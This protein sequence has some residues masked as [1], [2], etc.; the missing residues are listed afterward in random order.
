[1]TRSRRPRFLWLAAAA[2]AHRCGAP[3]GSF[4][5]VGA[6][7]FFAGYDVNIFGLATPQI[8]HSLHIAENHIG[9]T[10][11]YFRAAALVALLI[12]ASADL[13]GRRRLLLVT[14]F[15][16]AIFTLLTAFAPDYRQFVGRAVPDPRVRLCRGDAVLRGDGGGNR[17][18]GARLGQRRADRAGISWARAWPSAVFGGGGHP[19]AWLAGAVC[20]RR[21]AAVPGGVPAAAPAGD[22]ALR[23]PGRSRLKTGAAPALLRDMARQYP[24]RIVTIIIA[25]AAFGFA[26]SPATFL[27]QKYLQEAYHYTP[28]QVS[29]LLIPGGLV[30]LG[31]SIAAGRLSDRIGRKPMAIAMVALSGVSFSLF[32]GAAPA[33]A[34]PPLWILAFFGFFCRRYADRGLR[35]GDRAHPLPRHGGRPALLI[36]IRPGAGA[37]ALEGHLYDHFHGHGPAF[38][39]CWPPFRLP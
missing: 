32:F 26:I 17:G 36:E 38:S 30:G 19:A 39:G 1:M 23:E 11:A 33:W 27:A 2:R 18:R 14:I 5:L 6:A 9:L 24:G 21:D 28:G 37:L 35:A 34:M 31:L 8:Q 7:A 25:A 13:V 3:S 4:L 20:D 29:L 16:Q 22:Q 10:L 15:G 12:A